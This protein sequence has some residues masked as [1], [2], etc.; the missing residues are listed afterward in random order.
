M[1][2]VLIITA[3]LMGYCYQYGRRQQAEAYIRELD[4]EIYDL[5]QELEGKVEIRAATP[6][7]LI[8]AI[9]FLNRAEQWLQD[10]YSIEE[11]PKI[12]KFLD[13]IKDQH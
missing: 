3:L 4:D 2:S 11:E 9:E 6:P 10:S 1:I 13:E 8:T 5:R 12:R 7:E